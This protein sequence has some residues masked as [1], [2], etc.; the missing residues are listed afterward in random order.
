MLFEPAHVRRAVEY[1]ERD[2]H[3]DGVDRVL[4][5][6]QFKLEPEISRAAVSES[7]L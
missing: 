1:F 5:Q 7:Q 6:K 4:K 2:A 3:F